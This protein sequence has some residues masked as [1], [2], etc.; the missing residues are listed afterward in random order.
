MVASLKAAWCRHGLGVLHSFAPPP[1]IHTHCAAFSCASVVQHSLRKRG[2][3]FYSQ[4]SAVKADIYMYSCGLLCE[5]CTV[6]R[7]ESPRASC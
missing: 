2:E 6:G 4:H 5:Y 7:I 1:V 3:L